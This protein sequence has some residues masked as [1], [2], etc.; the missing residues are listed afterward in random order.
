[1]ALTIDFEQVIVDRP[2]Q[3]LLVYQN[4]AQKMLQF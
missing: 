3:N 1:M 4:G 2:L